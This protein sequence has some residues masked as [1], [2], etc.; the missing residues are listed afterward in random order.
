M[1]YKKKVQPGVLLY[2]DQ[3]HALEDMA[4]GQTK[5]MLRAVRLYVQHGEEPD[6]SNDSAMRMGWSFMKPYL[7]RDMGKYQDISRSRSESGKKGA[8]A[9]WGSSEEDGEV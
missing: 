8:K 2:W 3:F 7:D 5:Q 9:T 1:A 4:D 6:F